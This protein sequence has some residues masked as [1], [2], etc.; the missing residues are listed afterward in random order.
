MK[1]F[2]KQIFISFLFLTISLGGCGDFEG[3]YEEVETNSID[4]LE[5]VHQWLNS[6]IPALSKHIFS[7]FLEEW[8]QTPWKRDGT[9]AEDVEI[10]TIEIFYFC[11]KN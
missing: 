8:E 11:E 1:L 10:E 3:N 6:L 7:K 5:G 2:I 9:S 4:S